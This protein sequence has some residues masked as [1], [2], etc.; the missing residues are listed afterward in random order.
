MAKNVVFKFNDKE[1]E[2]YIYTESKYKEILN[3]LGINEEL[4]EISD[5]AEIQ[6][7]TM[8][9]KF[10]ENY[11]KDTDSRKE[12]ARVAL[13]KYMKEPNRDSIVEMYLAQMTVG[14][15][16]YDTV[17]A[18]GTMTGQGKSLQ[19]GCGQGKTGV[20]A[21]AAYDIL[22]NSTKE[23]SNQVF[24]TSS[25]PELAEELLEIVEAYHLLGK[26]KDVVLIKNNSIIIPDIDDNGNL[27]YERDGEKK[28][29]FKEI[30]FKDMT[31][32]E[33]LTEY[34]KALVISDNATL[35]NH[36]MRGI[37]KPPLNKINRTILVD[38]ADY[39]LLDSYNPM[40]QTCELLSGDV[41][42]RRDL[43][44]K[45]YQIL[46][47]VKKTEGKLFDKDDENQ[48]VDFTNKG[49]KRVIDIIEAI[50]KNTDIDKNMLYELT[51]D[52]LVVDTVYKENRDYQILGDK[53]LLVSENRASGVEID[54]PQGVKQALMIKLK[55]EGKYTGNIP[56][57]KSVINTTNIQSFFKE[58]FNTQQIIS[59]TL[60]I[61][62]NE[63]ISEIKSNFQIDKEDILIM[64]PREQSKLQIQGKQLFKTKEEK[65]SSIVQNALS[66]IKDKE[67]YGEM[68]GAVLIGVVSEE[69]MHAIRKEINKNDN[70]QIRVLT[71]TAAS[72]KEFQWN[73]NNM[74]AEEF[75]RKY[76]CKPD[77]YK[78]YDKFIKNESGKPNTITIG[79]S[80]MGRG[81]NIDAR[82]VTRKENGEKIGG[83]HV[84]VDGLHETSSRNQEQY[85][86]R[87]GRG[88]DPGSAVQMFCLEDIP[89]NVK[90]EVMPDGQEKYWE[91]NNDNPDIAEELYKNTYDK[92]DKRMR[93]V[94]KNVCEFV[95]L[96]RQGF[97]NIEKTAEQLDVSSE[98]IKKSQALFLERSFS[99]RTKALGVSSEFEERSNNY[100]QEIDI[101]RGM[102]LKRAIFERDN[103][104][105][106]FDENEYLIEAGYKEFAE[107]HI[108][109][110]KNRESE[111]NKKYEAFD[112]FT[113]LKTVSEGLKFEDVSDIAGETAKAKK[114]LEQVREPVENFVGR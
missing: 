48:Y 77:K 60:G 43:R 93:S 27:V 72:D 105:L 29:P 32:S 37:L 8:F 58:F 39:S 55:N 106:E 61:D 83:L 17:M 86:Y 20:I 113:Q 74:S 23:E 6:D 109:F 95:E 65:H 35:M 66:A 50:T 98:I 90:D 94:R 114:N 78:N 16:P 40:Q 33:L 101:Y 25:T 100:K 76:G 110:S 52:A 88:D 12:A 103:H 84:I 108:P 70:S 19:M 3:K 56:D 7:G 38:E 45:A 97:N 42:E 68:G 22:S 63:I 36:S 87:A 73:K 91:D 18:A 28:K 14:F 69:E 46:E 41:K 81:L 49:R 102:Y 2:T 75:V 107:T 1:N 10:I 64:Q 15:I 57:E 24:L 51:Y 111:I 26:A 79:T 30:L 9:N 80:I 5:K 89:S 44:E 67:R 62:S 59:G 112:I 34:K 21:F 104:E 47:K 85:I 13:E 54:F 31:Q 53:N 71:Y 4:S 96:T 82:Q 99:I 92:V 11:Y